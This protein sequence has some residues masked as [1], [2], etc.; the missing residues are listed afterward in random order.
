MCLTIV[1]GERE[2]NL[3]A[4]DEDTS[5]LWLSTLKRLVCI[6]RS[7][8]HENQYWIWL[9]L[10]FR[11][12]DKDRT[13]A[14]TFQQVRDLLERINVKLSRK[15]AKDL[16]NAV[17]VDK[18]Q[19]NGKQVLD[20]QEFLQFFRNLTKRP[21]LEEIFETYA[22][23]DSAAMTADELKIFLAQEQ[24]LAVDTHQANALISKHEVSNAKQEG[25][26]TI[27]G[28]T[29]L[30]KSYDIANEDHQTLFQDMNQPLSD[31]YIA[32]SHNT[33]LKGN[34]LTSKSS[35]QAY[36]KALEQGCRC[37]ELDL[38]DGP[39]G[40]PIIYHGRTLTSQVMLTDVLMDAIKPYAFKVSPYPLILSLESHLSKKQ[41]RRL[42]F[43]LSDIL[44]D[45]LYTTPV[46]DSMKALP[47]PEEL[48][49]KIIIKAKKLSGQTDGE[50]EA[51]E[52]SDDEEDKNESDFDDSD[53]PAD[54]VKSMDNVVS[55]SNVVEDLDSLAD[56]T[57]NVWR[58]P[59]ECDS[60][61]NKVNP[62]ELSTEYP[63]RDKEIRMKHQEME[64]QRKLGSSDIAKS[65]DQNSSDVT[66]SDDQLY[67]LSDLV[68]ICEAKKFGGFHQNIETGRCFHISSLSEIKAKKLIRRER[69]SFIQHTSN[70]LVRIYPKGSRTDSSN[71]DP[72]Q[73]WS[74][75]CQ[76]VALNYQT[77]GIYK[78]INEAF[79]Q[80]NG[81]CGYVLKPAVLRKPKIGEIPEAEAELSGS[82]AVRLKIISGQN[83]PKFEKKV[84]DP[85]VTVQIMGHPADRL[86]F[87]TKHVDD[88]GFNPC[89]KETTEFRLRQP[90]LDLLVISVRDK[91]P[92]SDDDLVGVRVVPIKSLKSGY[93]HI[94]LLCREGN[95]IP[96]ATIF[97]HVSIR[98]LPSE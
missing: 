28:F 95:P 74:A 66:D 98:D 67:N 58:S 71:Y 38:W 46:D 42:A 44:G 80:V 47:T 73:F 6:V 40:D 89:W 10:Q 60:L 26:L 37:V 88:N 30:M 57:A 62:E 1:F 25:L 51:N 48:I 78:V 21:E 87:K 94:C 35:V 63:T 33:Y 41:T 70:Q 19:M 64:N 68:N 90:E 50:S 82:K 81:K 2:Y 43:L 69:S 54:G 65:S 22:V 53:D 16:F 9:R 49:N 8:H 15:Y 45:M 3:I 20:C 36:I 76:I 84:I 97:L 24:F 31:Y 83:L 18:K 7:V 59:E 55:A 85:Y 23:S 75:G 14:L 5:S 11:K 4:Q 96:N 34:Q 27:A 29:S 52:S 32:S 13:G 17:N 77:S 79:F 56:N 91:E 86:K 12:A 39:A 61:P 92:M 72:S 93:G